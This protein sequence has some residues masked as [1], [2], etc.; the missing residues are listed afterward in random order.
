VF[1]DHPI[2][3]DEGDLTGS[4]IDAGPAFE[5]KERWH[6]LNGELVG[7]SAVLLDIDLE[8]RQRWPAAG[9]IG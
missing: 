2:K 8:D 9:Q 7:Q 5:Q 4:A 3:F 1:G 6:A